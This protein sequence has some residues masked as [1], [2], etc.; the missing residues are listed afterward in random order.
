MVDVSDSGVS[1]QLAACMAA[2]QAEGLHRDSLRSAA[3]E[4]ARGAEH[5][6]ERQA[7]LQQREAALEDAHAAVARRTAELEVRE[8]ACERGHT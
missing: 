7:A 2:W 4:V 8:G 3:Q 5:L 6:A 1:T